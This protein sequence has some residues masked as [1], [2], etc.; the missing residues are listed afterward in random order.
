VLRELWAEP[1]ED[2]I[3]EL[4]SLVGELAQDTRL[5]M[6]LVEDQAVRDQMVV[7]DQLALPVA[8]VLG[9]QPLAAE[10]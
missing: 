7:L 9:D 6:H 1:G 4:V 2:R 10:E 8:I 3:V 5:S